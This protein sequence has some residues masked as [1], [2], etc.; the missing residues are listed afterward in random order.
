MRIEPRVDE[1][2]IDIDD[3]WFSGPVDLD[4]KLRGA[5]LWSTF[6]ME[7]QLF[8]QVALS[9]RHVE[10]YSLR[11]FVP[12]RPA[13][14]N[15]SFNGAGCIIEQRLR[16]GLSFGELLSLGIRHDV[17]HPALGDRWSRAR[18]LALCCRSC[19]RHG[20]TPRSHSR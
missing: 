16:C 18:Y 3:I 14:V 2:F 4:G 8:G 1:R 12:V 7:D 5:G 10:R 11:A 9:A 6:T 17:M 15:L 19:N 13:P 20:S